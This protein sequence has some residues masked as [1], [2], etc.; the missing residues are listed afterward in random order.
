MKNSRLLIPA[1][2]A[3]ILLSMIVM[4]TVGLNDAYAQESSSVEIDGQTYEIEYEITGGSVESMSADMDTQTLLVTI[5]STDD[6]TLTIEIP[7][8][9][10]NAD[11]EFSVFIDSEI[12]N[13]VVDEQEPINGSRVI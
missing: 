1:A 4:T 2:V 6:G 7:T 8:D 10:L 3:T 12:G 11:E 13:F 5:N 9:A